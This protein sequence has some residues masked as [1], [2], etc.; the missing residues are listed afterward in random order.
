[1]EG[2]EGIFRSEQAGP[3]EPKC[4]IIVAKLLQ[5]CKTMC[6]DKNEEK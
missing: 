6:N 4:I 5:N 3:A 1:M 2:Q